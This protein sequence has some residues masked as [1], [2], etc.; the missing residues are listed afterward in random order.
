MA[1]IT[2]TIPDASITRIVNAHA[3]VYNYDEAIVGVEN[4]PTKAEFTRQQIIKHVKYVVK[5][6]E[7]DEAA[8]LARES[9]HTQI[10]A[11]NIT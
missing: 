5:V 10:D 6:H 7:G 2:I 3:E 1:N 4:P 8:R 11:I 9:A